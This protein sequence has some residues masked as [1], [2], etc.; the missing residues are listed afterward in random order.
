MD[1]EL[2][3]ALLASFPEPPRAGL[4]PWRDDEFLL[5]RGYLVPRELPRPGEA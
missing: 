4:E 1:E 3:Q 2:L 5:V